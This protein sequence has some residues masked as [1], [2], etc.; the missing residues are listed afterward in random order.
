MEKVNIHG[1]MDLNIKANF[2]KALDKDMVNGIIVK[3]L[4]IKVNLKMIL[5]MEK[6]NKDIKMAIALKDNLNKTKNIKEYL[7]IF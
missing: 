5:N 4:Y 1:K 7:Q 6:A 2:I 3:M